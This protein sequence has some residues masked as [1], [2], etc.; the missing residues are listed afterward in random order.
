M[1]EHYLAS[2]LLFGVLDIFIMFWQQI[3]I[4]KEHA[5]VFSRERRRRFVMAVGE[6]IPTCI[7]LIIN[8]NH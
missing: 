1:Y 7:M 6:I 8:V 2:S 4:W 3:E 5:D